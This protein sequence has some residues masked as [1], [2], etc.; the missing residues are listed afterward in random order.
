MRCASRLWSS[1]PTTGW[2]WRIGW[3]QGSRPPHHRLT[4]VIRCGIIFAVSS[5]RPAVVRRLRRLRRVLASRS[6]L[7]MQHQS[8]TTKADHDG[9]RVQATESNLGS[10][11]YPGQVRRPTLRSCLTSEASLVRTQ[12]RPPHTA[13]QV[14]RN[15]PPLPV[16]CCSCSLLLLLLPE[17][18]SSSE[19]AGW[20]MWRQG[21]QHVGEPFPARPPIKH[22]WPGVLR[23]R[24]PERPG[25]MRAI[26]YFVSGRRSATTR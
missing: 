4:F 20:V 7:R 12:L 18:D 14:E 13:G 21:R 5:P 24:G 15:F 17:S 10:N 26:S 11:G 3:L 25:Y 2:H 16:P 8:L 23:C 6:K 22:C 1:R 9:G 19:I